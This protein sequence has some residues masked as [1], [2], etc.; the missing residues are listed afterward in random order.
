[1][2]TNELENNHLS[3][4][5][6]LFIIGL[7]CLLAGLGFILSPQGKTVGAIPLAAFFTWV[8]YL[9]IIGFKSK[10]DK[11]G[12]KVTI[13]LALEKFCFI[14]GLAAFFI[15]LAFIFHWGMGGI[16]GALFLT[17]I[18]YFKQYSHRG[19]SPFVSASASMGI[20]SISESSTANTFGSDFSRGLASGVSNGSIGSIIGSAGYNNR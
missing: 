12:F 4:D 16:V 8:I 19:T 13:S 20:D 7:F 10:I 6:L 11:V 1:M 2:K 18:F 5:M 15:G 14:F 17:F 9:N 3:L